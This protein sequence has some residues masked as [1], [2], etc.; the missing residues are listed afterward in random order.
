MV[1]VS[2]NH[3]KPLSLVSH[4]PLARRLQ[5]FCFGRIQLH[6]RS[7]WLNAAFFRLI[8]ISPASLSEFLFF[9]ALHQHA[10]SLVIGDWSSELIY[11]QR[12]FLRFYVF[13]L[14]AE[15]LFRRWLIN[16]IHF[17]FVGGDSKV[18]RSIQLSVSTPKS[19]GF[20]LLTK[21]FVCFAHKSWSDLCL[22]NLPSRSI[23]TTRYSPPRLME[24]FLIFCIVCWNTSC[25]AIYGAAFR[26]FANILCSL[27]T[28]SLTLGLSYQLCL[29]GEEKV[30]NALLY[31]VGRQ[32]KI[33]L[34]VITFQNTIALWF[35]NQCERAIE[36]NSKR[37]HSCD[38]LPSKLRRMQTNQI[39]RLQHEWNKNAEHLIRQL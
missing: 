16:L 13:F 2:A 15:N 36:H 11:E 10:N 5:R 14:T 8:S 6:C 31:I 12:F 24:R 28:T 33:V 20:L 25:I 29:S 38:A 7:G 34:K 1:R 32:S 30:P 3:A 4:R 27:T 17:C 23:L 22:E 19:I 18:L 9:F 39:K 35:I 26:W 37:E 21:S